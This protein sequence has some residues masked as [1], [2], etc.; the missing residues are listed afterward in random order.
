MATAQQ[1]Q[2]TPAVSD[3]RQ[4]CIHFAN[5]VVWR[6]SDHPR[7]QLTGI[8]ML[9]RFARW[10]GIFDDG[11]LASMRHRAEESPV[12][13]Q[14]ALERAKVARE[15][16]YRILLAAANH[17]R[18]APEDVALLNDTVAEAQAQVHLAPTGEAGHLHWRWKSETPQF[19]MVLWAVARS[20][21]ELLTSEELTK[22]KSCPGEGCAYLFMDLSRNGKRRWCE[23]DVCGNRNKVK[24]FRQSHQGV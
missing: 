24:R 21:A 19:D 20:A 22:V 17:E 23:M 8:D 12:E 9:L 10:A 14:A 15:A 13:A 1:E 3:T 4:V 11:Q 2:H 7:D 18:A 16:I 6:A 5:L